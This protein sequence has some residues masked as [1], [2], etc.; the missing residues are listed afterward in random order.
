MKK[1]KRNSDDTLR[2]H[3]D[4]DKLEVVALGPGWKKG[5]TQRAI[6]GSDV[7][8]RYYAS[9][10]APAKVL[11]SS[12]R[13]DRELLADFFMIFARAEYAL[14][15]AGFVRSD[16]GKPVIRWD[17]FAEK[18][19]RS[20]LDSSEPAVTKAIKYL[21]E[22]PPARQVVK[23]GSLTWQPRTS[24]DPRDPVFLIRSVTTVR[25]NLF[26]GGKRIAGVLAERDLLLLVSCL[27]ILSYAISLNQ[28]VLQVFEELPAEVGAA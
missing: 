2:P 23:D 8:G 5:T 12:P 16:K 11:F 4:L 18:I 9:R 1:G 15:E 14:K 3:Y 19:G 6:G 20:L 21:A 7:G 10:L 25:N 26:H 13:I 27:N 17:E 24:G 22:N 28:E